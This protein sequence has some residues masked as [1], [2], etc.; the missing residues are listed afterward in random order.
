MRDGQLVTRAM[1]WALSTP[2]L[3]LTA[4]GLPLN[5]PC[6]LLVRAVADGARVNLYLTAGWNHC[7]IRIAVGS[8]G[9]KTEGTKCRE[10]NMTHYSKQ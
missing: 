6:A 1:P 10:T 8:Y 7:I 5:A 4:G 2:A 3:V 9:E